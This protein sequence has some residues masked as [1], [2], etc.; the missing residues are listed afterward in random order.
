LRTATE[1][2]SVLE[3]A[4]L[5]GYTPRPGVAASVYLAYSLEKD[6]EPVEIAKGAQV[7]SIPAPG[8]QMQC[9]ETAE[10]LT[11]RVEWN[12][13]R[14][15]LAAEPVKMSLA[16]FSKVEDFNVSPDTAMTKRVLAVLDEVSSVAKNGDPAALAAHLNDTALPQLEA[17]VQAARDGHFTKLQPWV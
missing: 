16:K 10:P 1:R 13:L 11:A 3:L 9:F 14:A 6:A 4:R 7:N 2:R 8:E 12:I 15:Q 5:I 17:E